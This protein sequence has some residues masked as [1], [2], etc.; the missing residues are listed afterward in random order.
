[1][2]VV[3]LLALIVVLWVLIRQT[4]FSLLNALLGRLYGR[5]IRIKSVGWKR[6]DG[7]EVALPNGWNLHV[8]TLRFTLFPT[9]F[10]KPLLISLHDVRVEGATI[11]KDQTDETAPDTP[12]AAP[13][14]TANKLQRLQSLG[15]YIA[16]S[17]D[18][19]HLIYLDSRAAAMLHAT[20][21][22]VRLEAFRGPKQWQ[23][24]LSIRLLQGK[25]LHRSA[26]GSTAVPSPP[27]AEFSLAASLSLDSSL[28]AVQLTLQEPVVSIS[29]RALELCNTLE[30]PVRREKRREDEREGERRESRLL[31]N[32]HVSLSS[33]AFR[34]G[35]EIEGV[36]RGLSLTTGSTQLTR[37]GG[38]CRLHVV[39]A[40]VAE[41][42]RK[43]ALRSAAITVDVKLPQ[44]DA[45]ASPEQPRRVETVVAT[46][47][48]TV[49]C[50]VP[51][52]LQW[53]A[54]AAELMEMRRRRKRREENGNEE[55]KQSP[56]S[57]SSSLSLLVDVSHLDC[58]LIGLD[59]R[60]WMAV[61]KLITLTKRDQNT[62]IAFDE[63]WVTRASV[64]PSKGV[65][66][67]GEVLSIGTAIV[68]LSAP[69]SGPR[70]LVVAAD[71]AKMEWSEEFLLQLQQL[72]KRMK[73]EGGGGG[74]RK[75]RGEMKGA[76]TVEATLRRATLVVSAREASM[77]CLAVLE[78]TIRG[79][80]EEWSV[81]AR[82][83]RM[84]TGARSASGL[85][86]DEVL[87][88]TKMKMSDWTE[89]RSQYRTWKQKEAESLWRQIRAAHFEKRRLA[90]N[91]AIPSM[92]IAVKK[93]REA[94]VEID[95]S[96]YLSWSPLLHAIGLHVMRTTKGLASSLS[97]P[98]S[99]T[100]GDTGEPL[101]PPRHPPTPP[102][103]M[104]IAADGDVHIDLELAD[105]H[106]M[107][108]H[109]PVVQVEMTTRR[110]VTLLAPSLHVELD[111]VRWL[112][113]TDVCIARRL[114]DAHMDSLRATTEG[115]TTTSN[116]LW[117]WTAERLHFFLPFAF[118]WAAAF[119]E[120]TTVIKWVKIMSGK[121]AGRPAD[122][123]LAADLHVLVQEAILEME[124]DPFERRLQSNHELKE[125]EV[126]ECERRRQMLADH[127][128]AHIKSV[129][130]FS[131]AKIDEL[132]ANLLA[133]NAD[134]YISR[135]AQLGEN[136]TPLVCSTWT[137]LELRALADESMRRDD[138][139]LA[140]IAEIDP[141]APPPAPSVEWTTMWGR[142]VHISMDEWQVRLRDYPLPYGLAQNLHLFGTVVAAERLSAVGRSLREQI[143]PLPTPWTTLTVNRN[144]SPL[145]L[146]YDLQAE[147][148]TMTMNYG[149]C[150]EPA[151]AM[152]S[153]QWN[154]IS[155]P[156]R[157]PSPL[158]PFWDKMRF[159]MHGRLL[160]LSRKFVTN[161]LASLDP[162]NTSETLEWVWTDWGLDWAQGEICTRSALEVYLHTASRYDDS[163]LLYLPRVNLRVEMAWNCLGQPY[164]HHAVE[165]CTADK[166]PHLSTDHDSYRAFRSL[167]V[168]VVLSLGVHADEERGGGGGRPSILMYA[169]CIRCLDLLLKTISRTNGNTRRGAV[170]GVPPIS[171][172]QLSKH[173]RN[174]HIS[175]KLPLF[176]ITYFMSQ[177]SSQGL[178]LTCDQV[179]LVS[180]L[181]Q[182][183]QPPVDDKLKR[184]PQFRWTVEHI[185]AALG[186]TQVHVLGVDAPPSPGSAPSAKPAR[187][188]LSFARVVH[189]SEKGGGAGAAQ[190]RVTVH[191]LRL[192]W[193]AAQRDVF[194]MI[195]EGTR[196]A[197]LLRNMLGQHLS[198]IL[199][200][201]S[202]ERKHYEQRRRKDG[203]DSAREKEDGDEMTG[204]E[205][206][207]LLERL[208]E[209]AD[210]KKVAH[211]EHSSELPSDSLQGISQATSDDVT[212]ISWHIELVNSQMMLSGD[213]GKFVLVA[214]S[215]ATI[216]SKVHRSVW[217]SAQL[218][219]KKSWSAMLN[220][221]QYFAP[222]SRSAWEDEER[223]WLMKEEIEDRWVGEAHNG[224]RVN[225][226]MGAGEAVGGMVKTANGRQLQR[227]VSRCSCQI[228][229]VYFNEQ[230][231]DEEKALAE[232]TEENEEMEEELAVDCI[233]LKHNMLE[234]ST[235]SE[236]YSLAV[237]VVNQL[238]LFV[239]PRTK[240][241]AEKRN[242]RLFECRQLSMEDMI[243][244]I[245]T[246]Q[247]KLR[248]VVCLVRSIERQLFHMD[249]VQS[250]ADTERRSQ[251]VREMEEYK[252]K[253]LD[254]AELMA[255]T[256]SVLKQRQVQQN[257]V[258]S[259]QSRQ[260]EEEVPV[261]R[262][263]EVCFEDCTWKLTEHDGMIGI[264]QLHITNFLYARTMRVDNGGEH[265]FELGTMRVS[266]LLRDTPFPDTLDRDSR[267]PSSSSAVRVLLKDLAPVGGIA[268]KEHFEVNIAPMV[269]QFTFKFFDAMMTFFF[270]ER[271]EGHAH[272]REANLD[273]E[274]GE[275]EKAPAR[276][277]SLSR[278]I[279]GGLSM[280][281]SSGRGPVNAIP[282]AVDDIDKMRQ[283]ANSNNLFLYI[284]IPEV[285]ILV[286][287]KGNKE[288]NIEDVRN[289]PLNFPLCEYHEKN[290]TWLDLSIAIKQR[291]RRILLQQ[292]MKQKLL[293]RAKG[294]D[295]TPIS[296]EEKKRIAIGVTPALVDK[297]KK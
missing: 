260:Q 105:Y 234:A 164:D 257:R 18:G 280:V 101:L 83:T 71:D 209:E 62:E 213:A 228:Y 179:E 147:S 238:V 214:A 35:A 199:E 278:R 95:S 100:E 264:A 267:H 237:D 138:Q 247:K 292:F 20:L 72:L 136:E 27:L 45:A 297:Q 97:N 25:A 134:I 255:I 64:V 217:R 99:S 148:D 168:N 224:D 215:R 276:R 258:V 146:F 142:S 67:W 91:A 124:D 262:K 51:D 268:V 293:R 131:Q 49:V 222:I 173:F 54:H 192:A 63:V 229:W 240:Q 180:S 201:A 5:A 21:D 125:D 117:S 112:T 206:A 185:S 11:E 92:K 251:L 225:A 197:T 110:E 269:V 39:D 277:L 155:K 212:A 87:T 19:A 242:R 68:E 10:S 23:A 162:Y 119:D 275:K 139:C 170:F 248:E 113:V 77:A 114:H 181:V 178:R 57:P 123:Q 184:R 61:A 203:R 200:A 73:G 59:G 159:L 290:W 246:Q 76:M 7:I 193:T 145:K 190:K 295:K 98:R 36:S 223:S 266:N 271:N 48:A 284:K 198:A 163:R 205:P 116:K 261:V 232:S 127:I 281:R 166:L 84:V 2:L 187:P 195:A 37:K 294:D 14:S 172:R 208:I 254:L 46:A 13:P 115:L 31:N 210:T 1:M 60:E 135:H 111:G 175:I 6:L 94:S 226:L 89:M 231:D 9:N 143:V 22:D 38:D 287:Y 53:Q 40:A 24:E 270:P 241:N 286:S 156:S 15:Q 256:I 74:E 245:E 265:L 80:G 90:L 288:K 26:V 141:A 220:G 227:I 144:I 107:S 219:S 16:I 289:L 157:D 154:N 149:P 129:P 55:K 66:E 109:A 30:L 204:E 29:H 108:W 239:D 243:T 160:W 128:A 132:Y 65:H 182:S 230:L 17:I 161:M 186:E 70:S 236:Q 75:E 78:T 194:L 196:R 272:V 56:P 86:L 79:D 121:R 106:V 183:A 252:A 96:A 140:L 253:Q 274:E 52:L 218:L 283:R 103:R 259:Q 153:L 250:A 233:T 191:E 151:L 93:G 81:V 171:K 296:D 249:N 285:P 165:L 177:S 50:S 43:T 263:F 188:L 152:M 176:D 273:V 150:W 104:A 126:F 69:P 174:V 130:L 58:T 207:D 202:E 44:S 82:E 169:N 4:G 137:K 167:S 88:S 41:A 189:T 158:L 279:T 291:S 221:M 282:I 118:N 85:R 3:S 133:K 34:Y 32:L 42:G 102:M 244:S 120:F 216:S 12:P 235:N 211:C 122:P 47:G 8:N 28:D 33:F